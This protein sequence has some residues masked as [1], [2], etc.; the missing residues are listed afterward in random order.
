MFWDGGF[1]K[2]AVA[3]KERAAVLSRLAE[4]LPAT[5]S[6]GLLEPSRSERRAFR[7]ADVISRNQWDLRRRQPPRHAVI[8]CSGHDAALGALDAR[9]L[10]ASCRLL[11]V[12]GRPTQGNPELAARRLAS[13]RVGELELSLHR[14]D[15]TDPL[16]RVDDYPTGVRPLRDDLD[17][18]HRVLSR[19]DRAG[20]PF[21]LGIVPALL[22]ASMIGFLNGLEHL[23][24]S[25]HGFDH[26]YPTYSRLLL[27][28]NDPCNQRGTVGAFDEFAGWSYGDQLDRLARGR[29][30]LEAQLGRK[31]KSYVPPTNT[32]NRRT[33]RALEALGFEYVLS[34]RAIPGCALPSIPSGFYGRTT[35]LPRGALPDVLTLHATWEA[36]IVE[37]GDDSLSGFLAALLA[38]GERRRDELRSVVARVVKQVSG[39]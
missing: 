4:A 31:V 34:E 16:L 25:Q 2:G 18:I 9:S 37:R 38:E 8:V 27:E 21:H 13:L 3:A 5:W 24:V 30:L 29:D 11:I 28:R 12:P 19:I 26:G 22:D 23:I 7:A 6:V 32:G 39:S 10:L 36:D 14:G 20:L 17:P 33:G 35:E 1:G 15:F